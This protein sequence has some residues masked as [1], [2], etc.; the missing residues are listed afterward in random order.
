MKRSTLYQKLQLHLN[1]LVSGISLVLII[2]LVSGCKPNTLVDDPPEAENKNSQENPSD[3]LSTPTTPSRQERLDQVTPKITPSDLSQQSGT[4][5]TGEVPQELLN[6]TLTY[7]ASQLDISPEGI[8]VLRDEQ[9]VWP[10]GALGCPQP[11]EYYIQKP[12]RGY[13]IT[14]HVNGVEYDYRLSESGYFRLCVGGGGLII[15]PSD[16]VPPKE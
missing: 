16:N 10:D 9:V 7:L 2:L 8:E 14:L 1:R 15:T 4:P 3:A 6:Q 11:D 13:W 12:V 5:V